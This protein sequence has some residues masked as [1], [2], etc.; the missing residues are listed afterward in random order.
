MA[1]VLCDNG[2]D[3]QKVTKDIFKMP[4]EKDFITCDK[5]PKISLNDWFGK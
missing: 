4:T 3:I 2:D 1:R 5:V